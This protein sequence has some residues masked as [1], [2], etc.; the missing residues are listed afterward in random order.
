MSGQPPKVSD[1]NAAHPPEM[2]TLKAGF[3]ESSSNE[4]K[5]LQFDKTTGAVLGRRVTWDQ[6]T[7][8]FHQ[9]AF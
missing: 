3:P 6:I 9:S 7:S 1:D 2:G 5:G 8:A 4:L